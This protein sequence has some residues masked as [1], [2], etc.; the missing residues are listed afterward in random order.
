MKQWSL[1]NTTTRTIS[2]PIVS[3]SGC[4]RQS[5]RR[6]TYS[7]NH[8]SSKE[9]KAKVKAEK[10]AREAE[11]SARKAVPT[12]ANGVGKRVGRIL[13]DVK[14]ANFELKKGPLKDLPSSTI[15][16]DQQDLV[17]AFPHQ[18]PAMHRAMIGLGSN[19][20]D[21]VSM[22]EQ[23]YDRMLAQGITVKA[24][25]LLYET[26]P[27]YVTDQAAFYNGVCEVRNNH[28]VKSGER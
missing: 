20:G 8:R 17:E 6:K 23:A 12:V 13:Q 27:M 22:I 24:T 15:D 9:S 18:Q 14:A 2:K 5:Y 28:L 26:A 3:L 16:M 21:R 19:I 10:P 7:R 4:L 1:M 25:S 11:K